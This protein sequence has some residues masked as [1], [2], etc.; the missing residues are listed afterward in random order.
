[1]RVTESGVW[2]GVLDQNGLI[3]DQ[4]TVPRKL[5]YTDECLN[6]GFTT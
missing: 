1:M 3:R 6:G 4:Y 2:E 5:G